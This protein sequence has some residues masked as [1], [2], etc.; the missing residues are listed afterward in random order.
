M[1]KKLGK[2]FLCSVLEHQVRRLRKNN[3]FKVITVA[4]SVGKTTTKMAIAKTLSSK[5]RVC[6]EDGNYN[7]RLT[8]PLVL[9]GEREPGIF[10][11]KAWLSLLKR[12]SKSSRQKFPYDYAVLEIGSDAPGQLKRFAYLNPDIA[13]LTAIS[14][15]HM[16]YFKNMNSVAQE[17][18][19]PLKYSKVNLV[20]LD[21]VASGYLEDQKYLGYGFTAQN[22]YRVVQADGNR[23]KIS[24]NG[25]DEI[26]LENSL[27][28][29]QGAKAVAAAAATAHQLGWDALSIRHG[30]EY[31][32]QVAGRMQILPGVN[33]SQLIDDTYNSSPLAVKAAL[34]V[35]YKM[36]GSKK[37]AIL[38][39][40]NELGDESPAAHE[41]VARYCDPENLSLLVTIGQDAKTYLAPVAEKAGCKVV[42]FLSPV[43]AGSY[44]KDNLAEGSVVLAKGSQNGVFAEEA[45]KLLL[46]NPA[47]VAKL[48]RQTPDWIAKK[49]L[50]F[51]EII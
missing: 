8:V 24:L 10:D 6:F 7:D 16:E 30:L 19:A 44:L 4:G 26:S 39:S 20:N 36:N 18:L 35:L 28:G 50:Q 25:A 2:A 41:E 15:E 9:F 22:G 37:I 45:L 49:K 43:E 29:T 3:D 27:L 23:L 42:S 5:S 12:T 51:P 1:I 47:D 21:D 33:N 17:E 40:M 48:V 31:I 14:M 32:D 38:G 34:D 46:A 11:I 13:I